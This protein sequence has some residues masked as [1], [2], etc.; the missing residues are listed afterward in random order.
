MTRFPFVFLIFYFVFIFIILLEYRF[1]LRFAYLFPLVLPLLIAF[2]GISKIWLWTPVYVCVLIYDSMRAF[3]DDISNR[4]LSY[5]LEMERV[6]FGNVIPNEVLQETFSAW[7]SPPYF[8]LFT[9]SYLSHFFLPL[10]FLAYTWKKN[11]S[12]FIFSAKAFLILN[13]MAVITFMLLP[14]SP[15]WHALPQI[16]RI[17]PVSIDYMFGAI[18]SFHSLDANPFAPFPSLHAAYP[19]LFFL[20]SRKY[21]P[22]VAKFI[23]LLCATVSFTL[24]LFGEHYV[25]DL[26]A[27]YLYA[28]VAFHISSYLVKKHVKFLRLRYN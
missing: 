19:F 14:A 24:V 27:G 6:V 1:T 23:L 9:L 26:L 12:N 3:A 20:L 4:V 7:L 5:P 18:E 13:L 10:L 8:V 21:Y 11:I 22:K 16:E 15:P 17:T 25:V 2:N 28:Y